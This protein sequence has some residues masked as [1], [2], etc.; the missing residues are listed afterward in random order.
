MVVNYIVISHFKK[1]LKKEN[2]KVQVHSKIPYILENNPDKL[3]YSF[4]KLSQA[5][6]ENKKNL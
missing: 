5:T 2:Q 4:Q 6:S 1:T 3:E